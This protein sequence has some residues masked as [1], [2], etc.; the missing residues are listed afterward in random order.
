MKA[1]TGV[2]LAAFLTASSRTCVMS[3][4]E[5]PWRVASV[6]ACEASTRCAEDALDTCLVSRVSLSCGSST[7]T[8]PLA[9]GAAPSMRCNV[10]AGTARDCSRP[11]DSLARAVPPGGIKLAG[12]EASSLPTTVLTSSNTTIGR[13]AAGE[14]LLSPGRLPCSTSRPKRYAATLPAG[15]TCWQTGHWG[16]P[17]PLPP[18][19]QGRYP[20]TPLRL[21]SGGRPILWMRV[22]R[23]AYL[24]HN[25]F[26]RARR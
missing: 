9:L 6:M 26:T 15:K 11:D 2:T 13:R 21:G 18:R 16:R 7:L 8:T 22:T 3:P 4:L 12:T 25:T 24:R 10:R 23:A 1:P 17:Q 20:H 5:T 14:H 19:C